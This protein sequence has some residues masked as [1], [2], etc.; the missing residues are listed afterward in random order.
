M[1]MDNHTW[2]TDKRKLLA[3]LA[4]GKMAVVIRDGMHHVP[5]MVSMDKNGAVVA[6]DREVVDIGA[7]RKWRFPELHELRPVCPNGTRCYEELAELHIT[8]CGTGNDG[9]MKY[10]LNAD[11]KLVGRSVQ[12]R[13]YVTDG[14]VITHTIQFSIPK[15]TG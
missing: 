6:G 14:D 3:E 15:R 7:I 5:D 8:F 2:F 12:D 1:N 10:E 9:T 13:I 4:S 11:G